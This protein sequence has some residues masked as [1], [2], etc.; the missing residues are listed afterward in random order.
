VVERGLDVEAVECA[1]RLA[2][3]P[4]LLTRKL[5]VLLAL[6]EVRAPYRPLFANERPGLARGLLRLARAA[7]RAARLLAKGGRLV[8]RHG[9][10]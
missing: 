3:G 4:H 5:E 9:L 6:V 8:R 2:G 1:L 10:A 7:A